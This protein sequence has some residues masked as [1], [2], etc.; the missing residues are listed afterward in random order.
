MKGLAVIIVQLDVTHLL[1]GLCNSASL[2]AVEVMARAKGLQISLSHAAFE[3]CV[4]E[5]KSVSA[6]GL[7]VLAMVGDAK[8]HKSL[9]FHDDMAVKVTSAGATMSDRMIGESAGRFILDICI[10]PLS[11]GAIG[12]IVP[13]PPR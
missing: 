11:I 3:N 5:V 7:P 2:L 12:L 9:T 6:D 10:T 8:R 4:S 13:F 1:A